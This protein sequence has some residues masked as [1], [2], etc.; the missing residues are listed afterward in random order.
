MKPSI[1]QKAENLARMRSSKVSA[2]MAVNDMH[3]LLQELEIHQIELELQNEELYLAKERTDISVERFTEL[4]DFAPVGYFT[5]L[6]N[7]EIIE[8]NLFGLQLFGRE[9]SRL[10]SGRFGF[11]VSDG[12]KPIFNQFLEN[13]FSEKPKETCEVILVTEK[14]NQ[15]FVQLNGILS[16]NKDHCLVTVTDITSL[17]RR[18]E[19]LLAKEREHR[20]NFIFLH[21]ILESP[22]NIIICSLDKN[23]CY[24]AFTKF[25]E[26]TVKNIQGVDIRIGMNILDLMPI[27]EDRLK[28]RKNFDR[29]LNG[30]YFTV[31]EE[32]GD[33]QLARNFYE[34]YYSP[35]KDSEGNIVGLSVFV[36]DISKRKNAEQKVILLNTIHSIRS[37]INKAI[38]LAREPSVLFERICQIAVEHGQFRMVWI[39]II[40]ETNELIVPKY[41]AGEEQGYLE[42]LKI[43]TRDDKF[44]CGPSRTSMREGRCVICNDISVDEKMKPWQEKALKSGLFS[45]ASVPFICNGI[46]LGTFTVYS[47][48]PHA[49][50]LDSENLLNEIGNDISLALDT[51]E[52]F[53]RKKQVEELL[54]VSEE[55][56]RTLFSTDTNALFLI[57]KESF[58]IL[59]VNDA[60]CS[61]FEYSKDEITGKSILDLSAEP[62]E[63]KK[64]ISEN[65]KR[66]ELRYYKKKD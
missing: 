29:A 13:I 38:V 8:V 56:Y 23:C 43:S 64:S 60:T 57:D 5:L 20:N 14:N 34:N 51:M 9:R 12:T 33:E 63:S 6:N 50:G 22:N 21:S 49:F 61:L 19:S 18:E 59:D 27:Q 66:V 42:G 54:K 1:R 32:Y 40:D 41:S 52:T 47:E 62:E 37:E 55:K 44:G 26:E 17:K 35:L 58:K 7:G 45:S 28:A 30:E 31:D 2:D 39:G 11:F 65:Q 36:I 4:Y 24:I 15:L 46:A 16:A 10:L 53:K 25:Y 3:Q 48:K